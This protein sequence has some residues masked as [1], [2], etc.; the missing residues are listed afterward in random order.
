MKIDNVRDIYL[1]DEADVPVEGEP[2][3]EV[4]VVEEVKAEESKETE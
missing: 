3:E 1:T 4:E 2:I